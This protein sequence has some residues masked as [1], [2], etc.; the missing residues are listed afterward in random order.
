MV[1]VSPSESPVVIAKPLLANLALETKV[2]F[3][4]GSHPNYSW[5]VAGLFPAV[6]LSFQAVTYKY[7]RNERYTQFLCSS[8]HSYSSAVAPG[9]RSYTRVSGVT[10]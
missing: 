9:Q 6:I 2:P 3:F 4:H 7:D 8:N 10:D 5:K 1:K